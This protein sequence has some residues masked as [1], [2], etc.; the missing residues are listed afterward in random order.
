VRKIGGGVHR[1][2]VSVA[3]IL[4]KC[5]IAIGKISIRRSSQAID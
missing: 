1:G 4:Q 3:E 5:K 2:K